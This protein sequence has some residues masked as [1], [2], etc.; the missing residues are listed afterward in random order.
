MNISV[1]AT[2]INKHYVPHAGEVSENPSLISF[3]PSLLPSLPPS[4]PTEFNTV[5]NAMGITSRH[6]HVATTYVSPS[7]MKYCGHHTTAAQVLSYR[8]YLTTLKNIV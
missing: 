7:N 6:V 2:Q 8:V 3:A 5:P 4:P 1:S